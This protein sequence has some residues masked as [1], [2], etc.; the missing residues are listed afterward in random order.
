MEKELDTKHFIKNTF[1]KDS[2][3]NKER[4]STM[5]EYALIVSLMSVLMVGA[6]GQT[7]ESIAARYQDIYDQ[8]ALGGGE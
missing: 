7:R 2:K 3:Y 5:V 6:I 8:M 4:G 1:K